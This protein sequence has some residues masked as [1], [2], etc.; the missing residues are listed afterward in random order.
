MDG[1]LY[2]NSLGA[3]S[4]RGSYAYQVRSTLPSHWQSLQHVCVGI[5]VQPAWQIC[6]TG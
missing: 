6:T 1:E 5:E 4:S 3:R 2:S